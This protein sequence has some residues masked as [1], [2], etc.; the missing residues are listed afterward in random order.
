MALNFVGWI[1]TMEGYVGFRYTQPNLRIAGIEGER[2]T[3]HQPILESSPISFFYRL[4]WSR[5]ASGRA[6]KLN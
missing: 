5:A 2:E 3:Q 4:D 6:C 1:E